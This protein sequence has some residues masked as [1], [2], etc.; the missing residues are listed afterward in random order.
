MPRPYA[1]TARLAA[2]AVA[3]R[4]SHEQAA[5]LAAI[6]NCRIIGASPIPAMRLFAVPAL[7]NFATVTSLHGFLSKNQMS[8]ARSLTPP[9]GRG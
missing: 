4:A 1:K 6:T 8:Q 3:T 5:A 2:L 9:L 7:T